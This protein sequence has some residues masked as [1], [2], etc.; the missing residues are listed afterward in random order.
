MIKIKLL[1]SYKK[2]MIKKFRQ[3]YLQIN[4]VK[5]NKN[6]NINKFLKNQRSN[7]VLKLNQEK[8]N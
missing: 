7:I 5:V 2:V 8:Y 4:R 1:S 6:N 3:N